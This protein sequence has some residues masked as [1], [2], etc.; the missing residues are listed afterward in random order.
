[1]KF[2]D[3]CKNPGNSAFL[4]N[5]GPFFAHAPKRCY[6]KAKWEVFL[7]ISAR[8]ALLRKKAEIPQI[9]A[10]STKFPEI[11]RNLMNF[12]KFSYFWQNGSR[13][14]KSAISE[15][16]FKAEMVRFREH[17]RVFAK[18]NLLARKPHFPW[19]SGLG[20]EI[21][22]FLVQNA[23]CRFWASKKPPRSLCL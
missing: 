16:L 13:N 5:R 20:A 19:K 8:I 4:R 1:M 21:P 23:F 22:A 17:F 10:N 11:P 2:P 14:S 3:S 9:S 7:V 6:Y 18:F 15:Q 12:T